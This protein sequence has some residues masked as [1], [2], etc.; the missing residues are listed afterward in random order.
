MTKLAEW[1]FCF[2]GLLPLEIVSREKGLPKKINKGKVP[3]KLMI[4]NDQYKT[5]V[6]GNNQQYL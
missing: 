4:T 6:H 1:T 2:L 5:K 3:W